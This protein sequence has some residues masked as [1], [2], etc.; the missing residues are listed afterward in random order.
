MNI[1]TKTNT[2]TRDEWLAFR[3]QG[4]GGSD[5]GVIMG[6]SKWKSPF[7]LWADKRGLIPEQASNAAM[8]WGNALESV[9]AERYAVEYGQAVVEW[10]VML[11][12][13]HPW[14]LANL[15]YVIV[16][17]SAKY[18][19]GKVTL[20]ENLD[21]E[22]ILA[23]L[24]IKTAGIATRSNLADWEDGQFPDTYFWQVA[25]YSA[26]TGIR[27]AVIAALIGGQG[28]V[29]RD[30]MID[31]EDVE[32]LTGFE[33]NFWESVEIGIEPELWGR[34][35]ELETLKAIYPESQ[36]K[37]V[38]VDEFAA[39]LVSEYRR[40][41]AEQEDIE[42]RLL[43][44]RGQLVQLAADA[45]TVTHNDEVLFTYKSSKPGE[46]FDAKALKEADP[47]VYARYVKPKAGFRTLRIK[48]AE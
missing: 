5:A 44:V 40:L 47:E 32:R 15:D 37:T 27:Q 43:T 34:E 48:G 41:K 19:A 17:P 20:D 7:D 3:K 29:V 31:D 22:S 16:E 42:T 8:E 1:L 9:V 21:P 33:A 11:Q 26:V 2:L 28:L 6:A 14:Q 12:G 45:D 35:S 36:P 38:E 18:P 39:D 46:T 24:E 4:I 23:I 30:V 25:H 10:P 13:E